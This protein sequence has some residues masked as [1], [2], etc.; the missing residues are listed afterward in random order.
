MTPYQLRILLSPESELEDGGTIS[1][2]HWRDRPK[3]GKRFVRKPR[4]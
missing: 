3:G 4:R 2:G 1:L